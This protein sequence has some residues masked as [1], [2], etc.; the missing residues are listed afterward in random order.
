MQFQLKHLLIA[1]A[2]IAA[3]L[4]ISP[5]LTVILF[6]L[7]AFFLLLNL[8]I[9]Q[10]KFGTV[11]DQHEPPEHQFIPPKTGTMIWGAMLLFSI[12]LPI[13][14]EF[15]YLSTD[16]Y[17]QLWLVPQ[18]VCYIGSLA[19]LSYVRVD[20]HDRYEYRVVVTILYIVFIP[21]TLVGV[22]IWDLVST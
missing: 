1:T 17:F 11:A 3:T 16:W 2:I 4:A 18:F 5:A 22:F 12:G 7:L 13:V 19:L 10:R 15:I 9:P 6:I 14:Q 8:V 21:V 20:S